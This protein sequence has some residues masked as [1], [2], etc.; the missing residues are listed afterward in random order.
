MYREYITMAAEQLF[1][2][3]GG[4]AISNS[5]AL[6]IG[7][8]V[9][10]SIILILPFIL[11]GKNNK[12]T[13][14]SLMGIIMFIPILVFSMGLPIAQSRML[15]ECEYVEIKVSTDK[16]KNQSL[17]LQQCRIKDNFYADFKEWK[18]YE[19]N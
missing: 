7:Y 13:I 2:L 5:I 9:F 19:I 8:S 17:E 6:L 14:L 4:V 18:I 1:Y 15:Q 10:L 3:T 12:Y 16:V 11:L